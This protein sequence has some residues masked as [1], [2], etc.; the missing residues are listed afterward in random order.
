MQY[1]RLCCVL[2]GGLLFLSDVHANMT[3]EL[4]VL[5]SAQ[6]H[7]A[8]KSPPQQRRDSWTVV[9]AEKALLVRTA[10]EVLFLDFDKRK[11]VVVDN[12]TQ[13]QVNFSLYD[14]V[15]FRLMEL[16]NRKMLGQMLDAA[17]IEHGKMAV[18]NNEH[19]FAIQETPSAPLQ[20]QING[21]DEVF[22]NG[23]TEFFRRTL[24]S[25]P[26]SA[27]NAKMFVQLLRYLI[28]GH[29]QI[30]EALEKSSSIP[31]Q[32]I[33][34]T[35]D[36]IAVTHKVVVKSV[37]QN[38]NSVVNAP[39]FPTR[40]A[41]AGVSPVD[42]VLDRYENITAGELF[43]AKQ[44]SLNEI[45]EAFREG[46]MVDALLGSFELSLMTGEPMTR[47]SAEQNN[48]LQS[49]PMGIKLIHALA[50]QTKEERKASIKIFEEIRSGGSKKAYVAKIFEAVN[51]A[52]LRGEDSITARKL[53]L[54]V[55]N[56]NPYV[57][58][59]YKDLGDILFS[60][61]EMPSAWRSWD[62]GRRIAPQFSNFH[63]VNQFEN[64]LA[65]KYPEYF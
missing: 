51:R 30:L 39:A 9:L 20:A 29:P 16:K 45:S 6:P 8:S 13:T 58:G 25:T 62:I 63:A 35:D 26:V 33:L 17:K 23:S 1:L 42:Q 37:S 12:A 5:T 56:V 34:T 10:K 61:F 50:S 57:A 36:F 48:Q 64:S 55:L 14:T 40:L 52:L 44:R 7:D 15:G 38:G 65:A 11:R 19:L 32:L 41:T 59:V 18:V 31:A 43:A 46:R 27:S 60:E 54:E 53:L 24:K 49:E 21:T 2:L 4:D 47:W 28:G 22:S 3:L